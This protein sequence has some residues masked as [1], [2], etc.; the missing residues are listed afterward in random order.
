[1]CDDLTRQDIG[2]YGSVLNTTPQIDRLAREGVRFDRCFVTNSLC[3]PSRAVILTGKYS[4][5]NGLLHNQIVFNGTQQTLPK[6]LQGAGYETAIIGKWHL[7]SR[8]TGFDYWQ[9]LPGQ[10]VYNNPAFDTAKGRITKQGYVTNIITDDAIDWLNHRQNPKK[11]FFMMVH[12]KAPH[13]EWAADRPHAALFEGANLPEPKS[14]HENRDNRV[15][16]V[17]ASLN[18]IGKEMLKYQK[19]FA[20]RLGPVPE[21]LDEQGVRGWVYQHFIKDYLRCVASIDDNVGRLLD[22]LDQHNLARD[23]VVFFTS[24]QGFF[25]GE[26]GF[27]D[28]RLMY[29]EPLSTPLIVRYPRSIA[30]GTVDHHLVLNLDFAASML[31]FAGAAIPDDMQGMSFRPLLNDRSASWRDAIYYRFYDGGYGLGPHE[32]VRTHRH[33]LIHFLAGPDKWELYDLARDPQEM[34]NFHE[35]AD[36]GLLRE[37]TVRM[38]ELKKHYRV[39]EDNSDMAPRNKKASPINKK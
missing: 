31:D 13:A 5:I 8:P 12:H 32:G 37:L 1:M 23:T 24:D 25:L 18:K 20:A 21:G 28:K 19:P 15:P 6:L 35:R 30:P 9:V 4:H 26:H 38:E 16:Q 11:P 39:P 17:Q 14:L 33:K 7:K 22:Y 2:T 36:P 3:G 29:E 34:D 10:G 27:Y